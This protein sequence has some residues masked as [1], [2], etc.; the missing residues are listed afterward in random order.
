MAIRTVGAAT[1]ARDLGRWRGADG[2]RGGRP[3]YVAL[4]EGI[5]LLV[6]DGRLPL[7]VALP[8]ERDL[9]GE[10]GVSRTTITAAYARLRERGYL[11]SRQ[12]SRSSIALPTS[13]QPPG[14]GL[15][16]TI[17][18]PERAAIDLTV[19]AL[20]A[21]PELADAYVAAVAELP[22]Y[23]GTHGMDP[24]G[25]AAL[26]SAIADRYTAA[27]L[28]TE[29]GQVLVTLGAQHALHL[30]LTAMTAPGDRVLIEQP[31]YPNAIEAIRHVGARPV[32]V[33]LRPDDPGN[34]WD[35]AGIRSAA[36]QSAASLAYLV[37]DFNNPTGLCLDEAGRAELA[38]IA[39][40]T[41][42]T[43]VIDESMRSLALDVPVPASV[44]GFARGAEVITIGS[45][46]K[47]FWG[48]LRVGWIRAPRP[49]LIKLLGTRSTVDLGT[50]VVDQLAAVQLFAIED[51]LLSAR[52]DRLRRQRAALLGALAEFLPDWTPA[53]GV[54]GISAWVQLPTPVSSALAATAPNHGVLLA[55]GTRFGV[56]GAF[57]RFLRLPFACPEAQLRLAVQA[58]A[59][60][61]AALAPASDE[62]TAALV[63]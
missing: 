37:P 49:L 50:P 35:L 38:A 33:V 16:A 57:E 53:P 12:G 4:A 54:G 47:A 5:R 40:T 43:I 52:R 36:R 62:L 58:I 18:P 10:L 20:P 25:T 11:I 61:Y 45:T 60:A 63:R 56:D 31:S 32:P 19:A 7:G 51:R 28:P 46:S 6:H 21:P 22:A 1:V 42:M 34:E 39:R 24:V 55:A 59:Q 29:P 23:L 15:V 3:A 9:A 14:R 26:R 17:A 41:R 13:A 27:G 30:L 8:S 48:G 44:A 2:G